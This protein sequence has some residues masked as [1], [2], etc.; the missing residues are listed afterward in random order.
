MAAA[1][2]IAKKASRGESQ[3][4]PGCIEVVAAAEEY[5]FFPDA[6]SPR[7]ALEL[8]SLFEFEF[9]EYTVTAL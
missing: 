1:R 8:Q 2:H 6:A 7:T 3:F 9:A 5:F 4:F